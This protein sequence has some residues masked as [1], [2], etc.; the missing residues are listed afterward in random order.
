[1]LLCNDFDW[2]HCPS[3]TACKRV[4]DKTDVRCDVYD[5]LMLRA[6]GALAVRDGGDRV[7][8]NNA[9]AIGDGATSG[10]SSGY[11]SWTR[12]S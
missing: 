4:C 5:A 8:D 1:M 10:G 6:A 9:C 3:A 12:R 2:K 7:F 11:A